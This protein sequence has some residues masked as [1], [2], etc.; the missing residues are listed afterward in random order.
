MGEISKTAR[1]SMVQGGEKKK[2]PFDTNEKKIRELVKQREAKLAV[3]RYDFI[4]ALLEEY[5][6]EK[7]TVAILAQS[8][9]ALLARAEAAEARVRELLTATPAVPTLSPSEAL[10]AELEPLPDASEPSS[11]DLAAS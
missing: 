8:T 6:K 11:A 2:D 5:D 10:Q 7:E 4:D 1:A 9:S 3:N